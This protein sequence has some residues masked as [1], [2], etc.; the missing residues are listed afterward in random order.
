MCPYFVSNNT[1]IS[2][3]DPDPNPGSGMGKKIK[4]RIRDVHISESLEKISY[5]NSLIWIRIRDPGSGIFLTLNPRSGM[6]KFESGIN[7]PDLHTV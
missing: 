3:A 1:E 2:V 5:L 7:I 6:E 4:I